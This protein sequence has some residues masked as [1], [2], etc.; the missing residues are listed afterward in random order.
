MY[1]S[2]YGELSHHLGYLGLE[3]VRYNVS[4]VLD[5]AY[6]GFLGV[7]TTFD[8]FQNIHLQYLQYGVLVF[9]GYDIL[10]LFPS[11]S[12]QLLPVN[13][14]DGRS[15]S[16]RN[17]SPPG[18][19]HLP[20]QLEKWESGEERCK[21]HKHDKC[22]TDDPI[23]LEGIIE[24]HRVKKVQD[25]VGRF[26]RR[27]IPSFGSDRPPGNHGKGKKKQNGTH[28]ICNSEVP[29]TIQ[30]PYRK[31]QNEN[32]WRS[33][34]NH[35]LYDQVLNRPG[36]YHNGNKIREQTILRARDDPG[37]GTGK[38]LMLPDKERD[39]K[40]YPLAES[41]VHMRRPLMPDR[42]QALRE[43]VSNWLKEGTIRK[44][45]HPEWITNAIL[46]KMERVAWQVQVDYSSQNVEVCLEEIIV[47]SKDEQSL[48]ED[49]EE[50]LNKLKWVNMKIDPNEST[51]G[52]KE[53]RFLGYTIT[54][55]GIRPDPA[56]IQ[57][58]MKIHT[59]RGPHQIRHLSLHLVSIGRFIPKRVELMLPIQKVR[60]N[61]DMAEG[62]SWTSEAEEA[63]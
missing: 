62:P 35:S 56:K 61:L 63:F 31:N 2:L 57:A 13:K 45:Q 22:L 36:S 52:M 10:I 58:V 34:L 7:W 32:P 25:S 14:A 28:G 33:R 38:E 6:W 5:T 47:K 11:W 49:L 20:K 21:G 16:F 24:G 50:T 30:R 9:S 37:R 39:L 4:K 54:E 55:D 43:K 23:I 19:R 53:G 46:I 41:I 17:I 59:P 27:D 18:K 44:F 26:L 29:V 42:R 8:I 48:I 51:F 3:S 15:H 1:K 60:Q 12:L 40:A